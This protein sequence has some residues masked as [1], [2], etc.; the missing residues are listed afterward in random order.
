MLTLLV[1]ACP[2]LVLFHCTFI[3]LK[4][5]NNL[6]VSMDPREYKFPNEKRLF[7]AYVLPTPISFLSVF[8]ALLSRLT[9]VLVQTNHRRRLP[10]LPDSIRGHTYARDATPRR[11]VGRRAAGVSGVD[12]LWY[13]PGSIRPSNIL[14]RNYLLS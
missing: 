14:H 10:A 1:L 5:R 8:G 11:S 7:Q 4:A 2:E 12:R 9:Y 13:V 6:T 3:A